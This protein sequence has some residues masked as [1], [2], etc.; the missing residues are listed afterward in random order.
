MSILFDISLCV[1]ASSTSAPV[2]V[3]LVVTIMMMITISSTFLLNFAGAARYQP[4]GITGY[5]Y[6]Q[7]E[8]NKCKDLHHVCQYYPLYR[9]YDLGTDHHFYTTNKTEGDKV[10]TQIGWFP[11]GIT[12]YLYLQQQP[13]TVPLYRYYNPDIGDHFYTT[14][15]TEGDKGPNP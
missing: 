1:H 7:S 12:G 8:Y 5:L 3:A 13:G 11:E 10:S 6:P 2:L 15:K 9:Y 14:N 4:E